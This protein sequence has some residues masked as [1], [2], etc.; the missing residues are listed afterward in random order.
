MMTK[1][2][3]SRDSSGK[4][5]FVGIGKKT[6]DTRQIKER[7]EA[8]GIQTD[9]KRFER[10]S[11]VRNDVEHLC[12]LYLDQKGLEGL[13]SDSFL[14]V[15]D[16]VAG[17]LHDDPLVLLGEET[18]QAMLKV[19]EVYQKERD[20][21]QRLLNEANWS[22]SVIKDGVLDLTCPSCSGDLLKP[23]EGPSHEITLQCISC[24][25]DQSPESYV[26]DAIAFALRAEAY[27][28]M[29]D[30]GDP[31]VVRCPE[32]CK[33]AFLTEQWRCVALPG[34]SLI[35]NVRCVVIRFR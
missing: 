24:G 1:I 23:V 19:A 10:I 8:L 28:A 35:E 3:P 21:C 22:A 33:N 15:R 13:I 26:P 12:T 34:P 14:I 4:I 29:D 5:E 30:G 7:F 32:C 2:I 11:E 20:E 6:V 18:W 9:W 31:P 17:A 27:I 25:E 16:F